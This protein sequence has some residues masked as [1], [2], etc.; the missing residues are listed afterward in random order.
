MSRREGFMMRKKCR[1]QTVLEFV[2]LFIVLVAAFLGMQNYLRRG[3]QAKWKENMDSMGKQY[4]PKATANTTYSMETNAM[5]QIDVVGQP[6]GYQT[7][8]TDTTNMTE[9]KDD[10]IK[11]HGI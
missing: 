11:I 9:T 10:Y 8:R 1:G 7:W 6:G 5:T 4:D 2:V 3:V